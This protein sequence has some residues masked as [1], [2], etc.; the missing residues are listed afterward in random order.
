MPS[1]ASFVQKSYLYNGC[2]DGK[3]YS[4]GISLPDLIEKKRPKSIEELINLVITSSKEYQRRY[5]G[6]LAVN[7]LDIV[8][9]ALIEGLV[10]SKLEEL[11]ETLL[12]QIH[13]NELPLSLVVD[14]IPPSDLV[15]YS[16][17]QNE[18]DRFNEVLTS[19]LDQLYNS[20][21]LGQVVYLNIHDEVLWANPILDKYLE[22]SFKYGQPIIQNKITS[23]IAYEDTRPDFIDF[24]PDVLYVRA[25]GPTGNPDYIGVHGYVCINLA[26]IGFDAESEDDFFSILDEQVEEASM[27]LE[28]HR[29]SIDLKSQI[30]I[31]SAIVLVGMN[32]ALEYLID[33]PLGHVAGKAVTY[34]VMEFLRLRIEDIQAKTGNYYTL[35]SSP[36]EIHND[37]ILHDSR[38]PNRYL[39]RGTELS[40]THGDDLWDSLE[41]Q[42]KLHSMYTGA[43]LVE[44]HV[45]YG[46]TYH[47]GC[48]LLV[49]RILGQFGFNYLSISPSTV[50]TS[51]GNVNVTRVDGM[52]N[53]LDSLSENYKEV[54]RK[55]VHY[56][57]KNR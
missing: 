45:K 28:E 15:N 12:N 42:K 36:C 13:D 54:H 27:I 14:I 26:K 1:D 40:A 10:D 2:I 8:S 49:K 17:Y 16:Q 19:S 52:I 34:K 46:L 39:T 4:F 50:S 38:L 7:S 21:K 55:R 24:D 11:V 43:A 22:L 44:V 33:A 51:K 5:T 9:G 48:K 32:E 3:G 6:P 47:P 23:T 30:R 18:I 56:A 57:V 31:Y 29:E 53:V 35:E 41:H 20:G 37:S 25:G